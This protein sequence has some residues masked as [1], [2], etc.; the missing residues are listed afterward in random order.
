MII[1]LRRLADRVKTLALSLCRPSRLA[2]FVATA[3]A[4]QNAVDI[5]KGE[6]ASALPADLKVRAGTIPLFEDARI[7]WLNQR[8]PVAGKTVLELGP[9]EGGHTWQLERLGA[10]RILALEANRRAFLKCLI[11]K[12][13]LDLKRAQFR[14]VD[15]IVYLREAPEGVD[16]CL[17]SGVLYHLCQPVEFLE[18]LSRVTGTLYLWTHYYDEEIIRRNREIA[19]RFSPGV[20][21]SHGGF[22]HTL[23]RRNYG[24]GLFYKSSFGGQAGYSYWLSREDILGALK[25][26]GFTEIET[27]FEER[28]HRHGPC[29]ALLARC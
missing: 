12:E 21:A 27:H 18:L 23:Y 22:G 1:E 6:W 24:A 13:L 10:K 2:H 20:A 5:F 25:H 3:D 17:A 8:W 9:L 29:F 26:F 28:D 19:F 14:C 15:F 7:Q 11:V 4:K 16:L